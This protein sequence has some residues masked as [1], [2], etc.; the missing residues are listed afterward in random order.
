MKNVLISFFSL[1]VIFLNNLPAF[2]QTEIIQYPD[3]KN[4]AKAGNCFYRSGQPDNED[5]KI[6]AN[7]GVKTIINFRTPYFFSK[8]KYLKQ[9]QIANSLG[10]NYINIPMTAFYPPTNE[11]L[12]LYFS[13]LNNPQNY[14]VWIHDANGKD[15]VGLMA[16]L[17]RAKCQRWSYEQAYEEMKSFGYSRILFPSLRKYLKEFASLQ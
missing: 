9:R 5:F 13:I 12:N 17:Y 15:R 7:L 10:M 14:P 2:S 3:I 8:N 16:A 1:I 4:F 6:M 11:Q